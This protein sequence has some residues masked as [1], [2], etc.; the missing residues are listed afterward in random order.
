MTMDAPAC[1]TATPT[2]GSARYKDAPARYKDALRYD[3]LARVPPEPEAPAWAPGPGKRERKAAKEPSA[4]AELRAQVAELKAENER[5][6]DRITEDLDW[7]ADRLAELE[8][9]AQG[10][11]WRR[12]FF[13]S[14][15]DR[16]E[17]AAKARRKL[18]DRLRAVF[19]PRADARGPSAVPR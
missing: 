12:A 6:V 14:A 8:A 5:L 15:G 9:R 18:G 11:R 19:L 2:R 16:S 17:L 13:G 10:S 1:A 4:I 3:N 7:L